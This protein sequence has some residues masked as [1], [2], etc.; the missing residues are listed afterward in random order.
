MILCEDGRDR[1]RDDRNSEPGEKFSFLKM[2]LIHDHAEDGI[3][4]GIP[5]FC[6]Q[7]HDRNQSRRDA[8]IRE[9]SGH[10]S[11]QAVE[12]V[13]AHKIHTVAEFFPFG[14]SVFHYVILP[15][16]VLENGAFHRGA[17]R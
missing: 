14:N 2:H 6:D 17:A 8:D 4:D 10:V 5:Y 13:L 11:N 9:I 1:D 3:V 15:F 16:R 12:Y 7:C